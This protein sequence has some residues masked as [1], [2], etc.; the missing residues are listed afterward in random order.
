METFKIAMLSPVAW[1]TPPRNYGPWELV[2]SMLTESLVELGFEVTLFATGDS[3]TKSELNSVIPCGYEEDRS[4]NPKVAE[5][6]HIS[7]CFENAGHFDIIHNNFDFLPLTYSR[8][9]RTPVLTTIH[10]FSS[11]SII[12][13][14]K[15]YNDIVRYVAISNADKSSD[16]SYIRT[17]YHGIDLSQFSFNPNPG[18]YLVF[19]GR[20]HPDKGV[21]DAIK[22]AKLV[23]RELIMAGIIQDQVYF[24]TLIAP[25]VDNKR[26]H[27]IGSVAPRQRNELLSN[28]AALLHP[29][30]FSEPFGLS[31]I[32]SMAC[33]TPAVVFDK[34][35]MREII[36]N[37]YDGFIVS[38]VK[39]ACDAV[40]K[41]HTIN[42]ANCL[43]T[44]KKRFTSERMTS[45]YIEVYHQMIMH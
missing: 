6:L 38:S 12:P 29:I 15:K 13:V 35:S 43:A 26:I 28:A 14:F 11:P 42:R 36:T 40:N 39:E 44:V 17:I 37:N 45:E 8:L 20:M 18:S 34:G 30:H 22:I 25:E 2:T 23:D 41:I 10:G 21:L 16:L 4:V 7:N 31:I 3:I 33:G 19:L 24:S 1:R 5:C 32:E 9:T 27:Y